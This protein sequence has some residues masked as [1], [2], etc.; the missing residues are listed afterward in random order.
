M[1]RLLVLELSEDAPIRPVP[2]AEAGRRPWPTIR[3]RIGTM[4]VEARGVWTLPP[5]WEA[6]VLAKIAATT[7]EAGRER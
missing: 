3:L 5:E 2:V 1:A 7:K 4:V 6:E